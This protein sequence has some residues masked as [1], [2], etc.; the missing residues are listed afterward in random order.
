[1]SRR[2][3]SSSR[4]MRCFGGS[5]ENDEGKH[6]EYKVAIVY[7]FRHNSIPTSSRTPCSAGFYTRRPGRCSLCLLSRHRR[8]LAGPSS[9]AQMQPP[10]PPLRR[11][12]VRRADGL[13][14]AAGAGDGGA[15]KRSPAETEYLLPVQKATF[16]SIV[17]LPSGSALALYL[18]D[19]SR[20]PLLLLL[21]P[22][23]T[24]SQPQGSRTGSDSDSTP[25]YQADNDD[26]S[27]K[28]SQCLAPDGNDSERA[29]NLHAM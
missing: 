12:E 26:T 29:E 3:R 11:D 28:A 5:G 21:T 9:V 19:S 17:W 23:W 24:P 18:P 22:Q 25:T 10:P 4:W 16:A 20:R 15:R 27:F 8:V 14:R 6:K 7:E 1:M 2:S 13:V